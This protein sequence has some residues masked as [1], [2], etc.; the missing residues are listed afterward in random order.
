M[1]DVNVFRCCLQV[2]HV[3][4]LREVLAHSHIRQL[5]YHQEAALVTIHSQTADPL[6]VYKSCQGSSH[7]THTHPD[8]T[9]IQQMKSGD[10]MKR[11]REM[12][13]NGRKIQGKGRDGRMAKE[14]MF[15]QLCSHSA[16]WQSSLVKYLKS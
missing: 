10:T 11:E 5:E 1:N 7:I 16:F 14:N 13:R 12:R 3:L 8:T 6:G 9:M 15:L 4:P 2:V